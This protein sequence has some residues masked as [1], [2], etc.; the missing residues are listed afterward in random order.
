MSKEVEIWK[1]IKGYEGLYQVSNLGRV[2]SLSRVTSQ[3][4]ILPEIILKP[5]IHGR[6]YFAVGLYKNG[7][8]TNNYIHRLV[9]STF[10][11]NQNNSLQVNHIDGDKSNNY[12]ENLEWVSNS[13][14][15]LHA[16]KNKLKFARKIIVEK[17]GTIME[18][19]SA[20]ECSK[21]FGFNRCWLKNNRIRKGNNFTYKNYKI[22][23]KEHD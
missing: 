2:K 9:A 18:F 17:D 23:I 19:N 12:V 3:N 6:G 7:K 5:Q 4:K 13:D 16:I 8:I 22:T 15:N 14:N 20:Q 21:Y 11:I 1:D 10:I